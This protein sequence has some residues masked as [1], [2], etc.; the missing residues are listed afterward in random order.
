MPF[1]PRVVFSVLVC[2]P[3]AAP[4]RLHLPA[5]FQK[6]LR[7]FQR[8]RRLARRRA[9]SFQNRR[10]TLRLTLP[11]NTHSPKSNTV[12]HADAQRNSPE[13]PSPIT[14]ATIGTCNKHHLAQ[15]TWQS[16]AICRSS[17]LIP[18]YAPAVSINVTIGRP[19]LSAIRIKRSAF[20]QITFRMRRAEIAHIL[21]VSRPS[22]CR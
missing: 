3:R 14:A 12:R 11:N 19:N 5:Q 1:K 13:L 20:R 7:N 17:A 15:I 18:G 2:A 10:A 16:P 21:L 4:A 6:I 8:L 9:R 22:A